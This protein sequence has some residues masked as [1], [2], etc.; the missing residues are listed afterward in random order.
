MNVR[1]VGGCPCDAVRF[2]ITEVFDAGYCHCKR[3]RKSTGAPVFAFVH[4]PR[5]AFSLLNGELVA[6]P[7]E[8][9][10]QG[11]ICGSCR[12]QFLSRL[13]NLHREVWI[14]LVCH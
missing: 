9:L 5:T 14:D 8:R 2:E 12:L 10:G 3:C 7:W 11:V 4:V 1:L 13:L 6:E